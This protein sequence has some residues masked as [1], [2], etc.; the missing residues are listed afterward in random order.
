MLKEKMYDSH[1]IFRAEFS[2]EITK[3][4]TPVPATTVCRK[5]RVSCVLSNM[6]N[7]YHMLLIFLSFCP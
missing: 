3:V 2:N 7:I 1:F 5:V 6:T 4:L